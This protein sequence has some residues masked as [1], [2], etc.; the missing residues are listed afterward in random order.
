MSTYVK[1]FTVRFADCKKEIV[2][3][4]H[5]IK[6]FNAKKLGKN[7]RGTLCLVGYECHFLDGGLAKI[8]LKFSRRYSPYL[9]I[10]AVSKFQ[11]YL[12]C[13][14]RRIL[15]KLATAEKL[16][17]VHAYHATSFHGCNLTLQDIARLEAD[18]E[19][20]PSWNAGYL[21]WNI[22]GASYA[23]SNEGDAV[24]ICCSVMHPETRFRDS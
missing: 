22:A 5:N 20:K 2:E 4:Q 23:E 14:Y 21:H 16:V 12:F 11:V 6:A 7:R 9:K 1:R 24:Q 8:T 17:R 13:D 15:R 18:S 10:A 19:S 3:L